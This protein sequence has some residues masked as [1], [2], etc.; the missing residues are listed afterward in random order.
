[1][2]ALR[3]MLGELKRLRGRLGAK[4]SV[5]L[6]LAP[7]AAFGVLHFGPR[8]G[9]VLGVT[10]LVSMLAGILPRAL[11]RE[12]FRLFHD[13]TIVTALLLG[14][15]MSAATPLY[16]VVSGALVAAIAGKWRWPL[17][18]RNPLNPAAL[19]R[20]AVAVLEWIDP[21][22]QAG[23]A[24][25]LSTGASPLP[26][27]AGGKPQP[28]W[29]DLLFGFS[30]GAIGETS[31]LLLLAGGGLLLWLV[32]L[33][34]EAALAMILATPLLVLVMPV[35]PE[36]VGHAPW[37]HNP[38]YYLFGSGT[39][40]IALFFATDPVTTPASR[41]GGVLFGVGAA[42]IGVTCKLRFALP[43]AEMWGVLA[44]N[45]AVPLLDRVGLARLPW[46][47]GG[48]LIPEG[49][50]PVP[51]PLKKGSAQPAPGG[52]VNVRL[53][54][55]A[56]NV[57]AS[58]TMLEVARAV[59]AWVPTLCWLGPG[60]APG[61]CRLCLVQVAGAERL[62]NACETRVYEG[63]EFRTDGAE[64]LEAR[65]RVMRK[66]MRDHGRCGDPGC[67]VER[68]AQRMGLDLEEFE[69]TRDDGPRPLSDYLAEQ[70]GFC[71]SCNRCIAA[72]GEREAIV[73]ARQGP[74]RLMVVDPQACTGCG[75]C[76]GACPS[77][78]IRR[79]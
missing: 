16:M 15:S 78:A 53:N 75:D 62:L 29:L 70:Q 65:R 48:P 34:R 27:A 55:R 72:C 20:A 21:P 12:R 60:R 32:V 74:E 13:G 28:E 76:L 18:G 59:D 6:L 38:V 43:G 2:R 25:D 22:W 71:V 19:G 10:L 37:A 3:V 1:M 68:L 14:L 8:A 9:L 66:I 56:L 35:T 42:A 5:A 67:E 40:L 49:F 52:R 4:W 17:L 50:S 45:L 47:R 33:K 7:A 46:R 31:A 44:M 57:E 64:L 23:A 30:Q 26:L 41:M 69:P 51:D 58:A 61:A 73:L 63:L 54:G 39:L 11:A 77:G 36:A 79:A 24:V